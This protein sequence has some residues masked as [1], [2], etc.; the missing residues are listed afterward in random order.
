MWVPIRQA[1]P[2]TIYDQ[3]RSNRGGK[4]KVKNKQNQSAMNTKGAW[5]DGRSP[6]VRQ[7]QKS[8]IAS[9]IHVRTWNRVEVCI[10]ISHSL[11]VPSWRA[12]SGDCVME[13]EDRG[14]EERPGAGVLTEEIRAEEA[15]APNPGLVSWT[16]W[17]TEC[18]GC[19][20]SMPPENNSRK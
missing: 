11:L 20:E 7:M 18:T 19:E 4:R 2:A 15:G 9:S 17:L 6:L 1:K 14:C 16:F 3:G 13:G 12:E 10:I 5:Q 8:N